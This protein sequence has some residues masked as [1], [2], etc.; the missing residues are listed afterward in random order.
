MRIL[1]LKRWRDIYCASFDEAD[2]DRQPDQAFS[3]RSELVQIG[4]INLIQF[5]ATLQRVARSQR[6]VASD[7]RDDFVIG[8]SHDGPQ[9]LS[10]RGRQVT[11]RSA[12]F[13]NSE[14]IK[15]RMRDRSIMIE[16]VRSPRPRD[17]TCCGGRRSDR[18]EPRRE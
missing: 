5:D 18:P 10:Q 16:P 14:A 6:R 9:S 11:G 13:T 7:V 1:A 12:F 3:D 8:F 4:E 17:G 2:V 15:S